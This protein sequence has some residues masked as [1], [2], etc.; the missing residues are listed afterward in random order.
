MVS[1]LKLELS[2]K[3]MTHVATILVPKKSEKGQLVVGAMAIAGFVRA[4]KVGEYTVKIVPRIANGKDGDKI[5]F[6]VKIAKE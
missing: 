2:D 6:K 1:E 5:E 4:D 3:E